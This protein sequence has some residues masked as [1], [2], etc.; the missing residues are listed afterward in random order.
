M[1]ILHLIYSQQVAGAEK[2]LMDLLPGLKIA[3]IECELICV[4][5][6]KDK[7]NFTEFCKELKQNKIPSTIITGDIKDFLS[8]AGKINKY[9]KKNN[10]HYLHSHLFKSDLLAVM[11]KKVFN[12]KL[13]LLSTKHGYDENYLNSFNIHKGGIVRNKYYAIARYVTKNIDANITISKA[14]AELY[15]NLR[16]TKREMS[17]IHH[18]IKQKEID[19]AIK[20]VASPQLIIVGRLEEMKGHTY[21]LDAMPLVIEKYPST[22]LLL[23]GNGTQRMHLE[24]KA[25][26][27]GIMENLSFMG[28]QKNPYSHMANSDVIILPSLYEPFGLVYIESFALKTP[29]VAF[30]AQAANEIIDNNETGILVPLYDSTALAEK[31]IFLLNSPWERKRIADNAYQKFENHFNINRMVAETASWYRSILK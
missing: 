24:E 3:G 5:T 12:R 29:V 21:L 16:L 20:P 2:Y 11:V 19:D 6:E 7:N 9:L 8:I 26:H 25:K 23:L 18:G 15:Y 10:I 30:N 22:K 13:F 27:M 4:T 28:F 31:I 14:M 1:K 17:F